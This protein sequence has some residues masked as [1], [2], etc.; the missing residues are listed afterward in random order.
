MTIEELEDVAKRTEEHGLQRIIL[1]IKRKQPPRGYR[2]KVLGM[3]LGEIVNVQE[4][5]DEFDVVAWF[6][7]KD[8]KR[9][10]G[11]VKK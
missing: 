10:I 7:L 5:N 6:A 8:V 4:C 2:I 1:V 9:Y 3:G 11:L